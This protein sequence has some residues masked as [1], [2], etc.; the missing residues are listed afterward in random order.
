MHTQD[1]MA[2]AALLGAI[3]FFFLIRGTRMFWGNMLRDMRIRRA[4]R[5]DQRAKSLAT[6]DQ[7]SALAALEWVPPQDF[8]RGL[9]RLRDQS[10]DYL[11]A[12]RNHSESEWEWKLYKLWMI[13]M[14]VGLFG[15]AI[16]LFLSGIKVLAWLSVLSGVFWGLL[17]IVV[18]S[19]APLLVIQ[20]HRLGRPLA[21]IRKQALL[22]FCNA[23][24]GPA[25]VMDSLRFCGH[26]VGNPY[27][28]YGVSG[29]VAIGFLLFSLALTV[30]PEKHFFS[31]GTGN[32][33]LFSFISVFAYLLFIGIRWMGRSYEPKYYPPCQ[34]LPLRVLAH[35]L[36][37]LM[38]TSD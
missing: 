4:T 18:L 14:D 20:R 3:V 28:L 10:N 15:S 9:L 8:P 13:A 23:H 17:S 1:T 22:D 16:A 27:T 12:W 38:Q 19:I 37:A 21:E 34:Y 29:G 6:T 11:K 36:F 25:A 32:W 2:G 35:D 30:F 7:G 26:G 24:G 31:A 33:I 5:L